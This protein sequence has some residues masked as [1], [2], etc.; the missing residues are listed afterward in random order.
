MKGIGE[1]LRPEIRLLILAAGVLALGLGTAACSSEQEKRNYEIPSSLCGT[2]VPSGPLESLLP[3]G[4]QISASESSKAEGLDRCLIDVDGEPALDLSIE[5][6]E[7]TDSLRD[8]ASVFPGVEPGD[9]ETEDGRYLY[10]DTG[11]VGEVTCKNPRVSDGKLFVA[12][13][14]ADSGSPDEAAMKKLIAAYA[15]AVAKSGECT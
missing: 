5:W 8:Y 3:S 7:D 6:W 13:R 9:K 10:S 14:V 15:E 11:A 12:A 1:H 4:D 2:A